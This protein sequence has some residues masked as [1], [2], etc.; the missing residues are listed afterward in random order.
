VTSFI[1]NPRKAL[2]FPL[3]CG[4]VLHGGEGPERCT[5]V[6]VSV[7]GC[8]LVAAQRLPVG[9]RLF[10]RLTEPVS[11]RDLGVGGT[12]VW[13]TSEPPGHAGVRF[14]E[15]GQPQVVRWVD[16]IAGDRLDLLLH[17]RVPDRL[18]LAS[19][20]YVAPVPAAPPDLG[21][22]EAAV[23]RLACR[24]RTVG[25]LRAQLGA[26]WSRAQRALFALLT[27]GVLTLDPAEAGDPRAW[28][29]RLEPRPAPG[30]PSPRRHGGPPGE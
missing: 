27:R 7:L 6:N 15:A 24:R 22:E 10:L 11:G 28:L 25:D 1:Q 12:V 4:A 8:H 29:E 18:G 2:R 16:A 13:A 9:E 17:D 5:T 21:D 30:G 19:R 3:R 26:D 23:L 14:D 20:L